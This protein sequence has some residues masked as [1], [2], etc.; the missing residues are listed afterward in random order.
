MSEQ[1]SEGEGDELTLHQHMVNLFS[2]ASDDN[3]RKCGACERACA[4]FHC[5]MCF[6][7]HP[8]WCA[9]VFLSL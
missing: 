1:D 3:G 8:G 7:R 9:V 6:Q 4:R 2:V 5:V